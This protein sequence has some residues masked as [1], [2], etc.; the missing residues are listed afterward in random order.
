MKTY[1]NR[2]SQLKKSSLENFKDFKPQFFRLSEKIEEMAFETL[3]SNKSPFVSDFIEDQLREFI[4]STKKI[5][6]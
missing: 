1:L 5:Y 2:L 6:E 4:K 3:L